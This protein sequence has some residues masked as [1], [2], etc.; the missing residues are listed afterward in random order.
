MKEL[1]GKE[2]FTSR[3]VEEYKGRLRDKFSLESVKDISLATLIG[4]WSDE[5]FSEA[6]GKLYDWLKTRK[7][8]QD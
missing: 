2:E 8:K 5:A 1:L 4:L 6:M 7:G 3:A